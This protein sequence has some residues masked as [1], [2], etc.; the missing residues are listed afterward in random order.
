MSRILKND[1][2]FEIN[3]ARRIVDTRN[4]VIR[5]YDSVSEEVIWDLVI[6]E[7][8]NLET[9]IKKLLKA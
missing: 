6:R 2:S 7:L 8:P 1:P 3:N 4:R 9:E 5:G